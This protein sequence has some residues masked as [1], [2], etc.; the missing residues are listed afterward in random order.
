MIIKKVAKLDKEE[1]KSAEVIK[2]VKETVCNY[3][4]NRDCN[5]CPFECSCEEWDKI[6][7][8]MVENEEIRIDD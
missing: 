2:D 3:L 7:E 5:G 4:M 1:V 8:Q 6:L